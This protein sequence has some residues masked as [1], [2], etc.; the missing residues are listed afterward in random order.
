MTYEVINDA[1]V[2]T[3]ACE[4]T[5]E[6]VAQAVPAFDMLPFAVLQGVDELGL[7]LRWC[8][9]TIFGKR[10]LASWVIRQPCLLYTSDAADE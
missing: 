6:A 2:D 1:L 9:F 5:D 10:E 4:I 7:D 8:Q 3:R